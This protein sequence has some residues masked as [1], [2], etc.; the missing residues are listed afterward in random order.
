MVMTPPAL[1]LTSSRLAAVELVLAGL[2]GPIVG[3]CLPGKR[4]IGWSEDSTLPVPPDL[5]VRAAREGSLVLT[6][7]DGTPLATVNV[8]AV[9]REF[10]AGDLTPLQPAEHGPARDIRFTVADRSAAVLALFSA[11]P[12][13]HQVAR[14]IEVAAG[15]PLLLVAVSWNSAAADFAIL[16]TINEVRRCADEVPLATARYLA[17][18]ELSPGIA[19]KAMLAMALGS[20]VSRTVLD[21]TDWEAAGSSTSTIPGTVVLFTGL[22]GS[23]KS[24]VA[25]ALAERLGTGGLRPALLDGDDVRRTLSPTLGFSAADREENVRRIGWVAALVASA[26]GI[27]ICAPIAPFARA[28]LELRQQAEP[29]SRFILVWV[30]TPLEI[31]EARDRKGLYALARAGTLTDFTGIDSPYEIPDDADVVID[32]SLRDIAACVDEIMAVLLA[33]DVT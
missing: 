26:G 2:A 27:A 12:Q 6:D 4:P 22:S 20:D 28:R 31:C 13:A 7:P 16:E 8:T 23:G 17:L 25:R 11:T 14:A 30:S 33:T 21:F 19:S 18:A 29:A 15:R 32:T 24:T 5:A 10:V 9:D 3:Y 1:A